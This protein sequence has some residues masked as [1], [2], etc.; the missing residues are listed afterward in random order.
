MSVTD[1]SIVIDDEF[2][3]LIPP[4]SC[5]EREQLESNIKLDGCR[6]PLVVW[7]PLT[8]K[9]D[10][11]S[12]VLDWSNPFYSHVTE[13]FGDYKTWECEELDEEV[14]SH[15]WP[16]ILVDG[17]NRFDICT[18]HD[19]WFEV[20]EKEFESREE[21]KRWIIENQ[22][23]RRNLSPDQLSLFRGMLYNAAKKT[24][25][26]ERESS[27]QNDNLPKTSEALARQ[28]GVGV[29]TIIRDGKFAEAVEV[30][31]M[32][33]E[34]ASGE[35]PAPKAAIVEAAKPIIEAKKAHDRWER[36][37]EKTP[38]APPPEPPLPTEEDIKKAKAHVANNSGD[39]E[40]YTPKE[41]IDAAISVMDI[42]DLD[43]ASSPI[44]NSVVGAS[45]FYT[46]S[47]DGLSK[48]WYGNIWMNPPY[49]QPLIR[50]FCEKLAK[51]YL[52]GEVAQA[53]VLVNNATETAWF[54]T[55]MQAG[56]AICLPRGR[57]KFWHP[58][59]ENAQPLQGQSIVYLGNRAVEF[60]KAFSAF[61][62]T[63]RKDSDA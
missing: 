35:L 44:A 33:S 22:L 2:K 23:G 17:H 20:F 61:G 1:G 60:C 47:D 25:G 16:L 3:R 15:D 58:D 46:A 50:L 5:E 10:G 54:Q 26:G 24:H 42:I 62:V 34:V 52:D 9:P 31:G 12:E 37:A 59:K 14:T 38:L 36:E 40:W 30:L 43:P 6:E 45:T 27:Y 41:Y 51:A 63:F 57:I 11:W 56:D 29:A 55:L 48:H 7:R 53:V 13:D 19:I 49:A 21:A 32:E 8:W 28:H 4:L 39:N 18:K